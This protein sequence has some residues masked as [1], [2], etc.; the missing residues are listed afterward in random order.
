M[1][2]LKEDIMVRIVMVMMM[3]IK[4]FRFFE[5]DKLEC[6]FAHTYC[7]QF[8]IIYLYNFFFFVVANLGT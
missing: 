6:S 7:R 4:Q 3:M 1:Q 8:V 2:P 5:L